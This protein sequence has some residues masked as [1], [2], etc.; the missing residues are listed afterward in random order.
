MIILSLSTCSCMLLPVLT[1]LNRRGGQPTI[2]QLNSR[3]KCID[4]TTSIPIKLQ[5]N[6]WGCRKAK[7][8]K[9]ILA[10]R[11]SQKQVEKL[12]NGGTVLVLGQTMLETQAWTQT[13]S[14]YN[15]KKAQR[16]Q[17]ITPL[18]ILLSSFLSLLF[19]FLFFFSFLLF[20]IF[21]LLFFYFAQL[22]QI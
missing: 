4:A 16:Q 9:E 2:Q 1:T 8:S 18:I 3:S 21:L 13:K 5:L 15:K 20:L 19:R 7:S 14:Q 12:F 10:P 22:E 6:L 17:A 11:Q